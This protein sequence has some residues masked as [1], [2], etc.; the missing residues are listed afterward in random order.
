MKRRLNFCRN[1]IIGFL[2]GKKINNNSQ[3]VRDM[4]SNLKPGDI[5][6]VKSKDEIQKTLNNW[7]QLKG[8]AFME[9]MWPYCGTKQKVLK[10]VEKFLDERDYLIKKC[11]GIVI[12][13]GVMCQ[14]TKD[15][16]PCDRSCFFFWREEWLKKINYKE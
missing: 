9:E 12:L 8:C 7:N 16:G 11:N 1:L 5:V 2:G 6:F 10:R 3:K 15:F 4:K 14:G 13:E